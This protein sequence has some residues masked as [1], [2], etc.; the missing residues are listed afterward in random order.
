M[1][2]FS[3]ESK[4]VK[5]KVCLCPSGFYGLNCELAMYTKCYVNI[6]QPATY[7]TESCRA[8]RNDS[9]EYMYSIRGYDPCFF[10][11][12]SLS[13][14]FRF[15]LECKYLDSTGLVA[16]HPYS[17]GYKYE[18]VIGKLEYD[19]ERFDFD[20][21]EAVKMRVKNSTRILVA[22]DFYNW[23]WISKFKRFQTHVDD[24]EVLL[25]NK[26]GR[27]WVD[28]SQME[29]SDK[30]KKSRFEV[31]GR[32]YYEAHAFGYLLNSFTSS[33]FVDRL[34][35]ET[36]YLRSTKLEALEKLY[37]EYK[38]VIY[39]AIVATVLYIIY[40]LYTQKKRIQEMEKHRKV[41]KLK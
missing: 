24:K 10:F 38:L 15:K 34:G 29:E 27:I 1:L 22:I 19:R 21:N 5:N 7:D 3:L 18:D 6:T 35:Y 33:G 40:Y 31:A 4:E 23:K 25:G 28:F 13:Y 36:P 17:L 37:N 41:I 2:D 8:N 20:T 30:Q 12:F 26:E 11:N 9:D 16:I 14:E 32:M 39:G